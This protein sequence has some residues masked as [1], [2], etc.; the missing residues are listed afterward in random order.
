[1]YPRKTFKTK[2]ESDSMTEKQSHF[3]VITVADIYTNYGEV[4]NK[5][6]ATTDNNR[7]RV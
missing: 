2:L 4:D 1:V 5:Q 6:Q 7:Q 3:F